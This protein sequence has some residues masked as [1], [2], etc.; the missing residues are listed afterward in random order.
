MEEDADECH[1]D[2]LLFVK[3]V[4]SIYHF[5]L[6]H[7]LVCGRPCSLLS[8]CCLW[9]RQVGVDQT[10]AIPIDSRYAQVG[11]NE[12]NGKF[13]CNSELSEA[14]FLKRRSWNDGLK[15][16]GRGRKGSRA[17]AVCSAP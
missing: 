5:R 16:R 9:R 2:R 17:A 3:K 8:V 4:V 7:T 1:F 10:T 13:E 14:Q 12:N 11:Q 15:F 6:S